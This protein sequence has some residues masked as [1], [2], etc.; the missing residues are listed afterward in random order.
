[1]SVFL[2]LLHDHAQR[3]PDTEVLFDEVRTKGVSYGELDEL[4]GRVYGW[5]KEQGLGKEDFVMINLPRGVLPV[6]AMLGI[7][8]AGAAWVLVEDTYAPERIA[9]IREDCGCKAEINSQNWEQILRRKA[10]DGFVPTGGHD[11]AYAVYTSGTA[12]NPKGVLHEW[13]N[14]DRTCAAIQTEGNN[15]FAQKDRVALLSPL[16]FVASVMVIVN[17]LSIFGVKLY[18][19]SYATLKNPDALARYFFDKRISETF[20][21][22]SYVRKI[23]NKIGP[24]LKTLF[25]GSE[26]ANNVFIENVNLYNVYAASETGGASCVFKIDRPYEIC[27]VG[28]PEVEGSVI[29][30]GEDGQPVPDGETGEVC[31]EATYVRG[32]INLPEETEHSFVDGFFRTADLAYKNENG[33]FVL[34]GRKGDMIK[35]NDNRIE[36]AEIEAAVCQALGID[37]AAAR[38][39][40]DDDRSFL[41]VYYTADVSFDAAQLRKEL[42]KRLPY[43]MIPAF[44]MKIDVPPLKANG[45]L[46]RKALPRPNTDDYRSD[47]APPTNETEEKLCRAMEKV[48]NLLRVGIHD[49]FYEMGG[50]SLASM[51]M[52][53][54]S[55]LPDLNAGEV[56]RGRTPEQIAKIYGSRRASEGNIDER[57]DVS[58]LRPHPLTVEQMYMLD[59]Q[60]YTPNSTMYNLFKL[61]RFDKQRYDLRK[62]ASAMGTVIQNH[63]ALLTVYS[64]DEDGMPVQKY[65][66]E[67]FE[68][69]RVEKLTEFEFR[70]V[71]D[72]LIYPYKIIGGKLCRCRMFETEKAG[73]LFFDVHH[74]LF[75]GTSMKVFWSN[76]TNAFLGIPPEK[77]YYY[78]M[79]NQREAGADS[80]LYQEARRYFEAKYDGVAWSSFPKI[81]HPSRDSVLEEYY[82]PMEVTDRQ[83]KAIEKT[84]MISRNEFFIVAAA[85][86]MSV[87]NGAQDVKLSWIF[88]GRE[89]VR[90]MSSVGLLFRALPVGL[91]FRDD[92]TLRN[93]FS[94]VR[95]QVQDGIRYSVY[96]Y[97]DLH[98]EVAGNEPA[99]VLYQRDIRDAGVEGLDVEELEP[100][101]NESAAEAILD[102]EVLDG[103]DG[104]GV[105]AGFN[106][107]L[108]EEA[109]M[110][111]FRDLIVRMSQ[112]LASYNTQTDVTIGEIKAQV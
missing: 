104:L 88:N 38:G 29:L 87:Y 106:A 94:D 79:L 1:M 39:F 10:L 13:G 33:D 44:F 17:N 55:G 48:L 6:I 2:E 60:L 27:P 41:C 86:A 109:S 71:K 16:N 80:T 77:D 93:V 75:D 58:R 89:D 45:K 37:W 95:T 32:Y 8:K 46:D 74:S 82:A 91:R 110:I 35:I 7:W 67:N 18:I 4:S 62:L 11:A 81:D 85:L 12:G 34:L 9:F 3:G 63:P 36:P 5:V 15:P 49:D 61:L 78:S 52:I 56:F 53:V 97:V 19:V 84:Y 69:I 98:N 99:Y 76:V 92:E 59:Y 100:R 22:P 24:Y 47:Y 28:K 111:R 20:L 21:T 66:P 42:Q 31:F 70:F 90:M 30:I 25:L 43:Y 72:T 50:D 107:S 54:E 23:G 102:I 83:L 57:D 96:P 103:E 108:Y 73:Y 26:P 68:E 101:W 40:E 64:Y 65:V 14:F 51:E 112:I 105:L